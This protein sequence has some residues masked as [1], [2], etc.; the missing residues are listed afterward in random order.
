MEWDG[1]SGPDTLDAAG[2]LRQKTAPA[3]GG[4]KHSMTTLDRQ[5]RSRDTP[6]VIQGDVQTKAPM[7]ISGCGE[8]A[9]ESHQESLVVIKVPVLNH[10]VHPSGNTHTP[11]SY[12]NGQSL[13]GPIS[14]LHR[15]PPPTIPGVDDGIVY[16]FH[17]D[18]CQGPYVDR[19]LPPGKN[20]PECILHPVCCCTVESGLEE[21][22]VHA[23]GP[24]IDERTVGMRMSMTVSIS[25]KAS[26]GSRGYLV[27]GSTVVYCQ[28]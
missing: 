1:E 21:D 18:F 28:D 4:C 27:T 13:T 16:Q 2:T 12:H 20:P 14:K 10:L 26:S 19:Q 22:L 8:S 17:D 24:G 6:R 25:D 7:G 23:T 3:C 5:R 9:F 11:V 15:A